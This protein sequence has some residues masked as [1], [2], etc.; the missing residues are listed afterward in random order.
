MHTASELITF[1]ERLFGQSQIGSGGKEIVVKC[2]MPA[3]SGSSKKKLSINVETHKNHCWVCGWRARSLAPLIFKV[4]TKD[5]LTA[6]SSFSGKKFTLA[7]SDDIESDTAQKQLKLPYGLRNYTLDVL[8][9]SLDESG[10]WVHSY[11]KKRGIGLDTAAYFC[12]KYGTPTMQAVDYRYAVVIPSYDQNFELNYY[13]ARTTLDKNK[14][15]RYFNA[16]LDADTI[17]FREMHIDWKSEILM[18]EGP[19]D[20]MA[21]GRRNSV[22][23][24]GSNLS[25]N[26]ALFCSLVAHGAR[27]C[28]LYD[29]NAQHK[30]KKIATDLTDYGVSVRTIDWSKISEKYDDLGEM[31]GRQ[32]EIENAIL[33]SKPHVFGFDEMKQRL[34]K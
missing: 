9:D 27:V 4:G 10:K 34:M 23:T 28:I 1:V 22:S 6:Y 19:F 12:L 21:L 30:T 17:I 33:S 8:N 14:S 24:L 31:T 3:C 25:P 32:E 29:R 13:T 2:P 15:R 7:Q 26:H 20:A 11:L 18:V 16:N 5:D